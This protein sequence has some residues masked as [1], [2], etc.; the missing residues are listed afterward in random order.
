MRDL[1]AWMDGFWQ[2]ALDAYAKAA[3]EARQI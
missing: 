3:R 1:R 2:E